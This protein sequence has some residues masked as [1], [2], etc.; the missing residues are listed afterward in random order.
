M[1]SS[2]EQYQ[3]KLMHNLLYNS[4]NTNEQIISQHDLVDLQT[5][6]VDLQTFNKYKNDFDHYK[7][8][9]SA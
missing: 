3:N 2:K 7:D 6:L 4:D 8:Q 5:D 1:K 9:T